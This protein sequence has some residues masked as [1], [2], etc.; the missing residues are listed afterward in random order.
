[1][2]MPLDLRRNFGLLVEH[3]MH[4]TPADPAKTNRIAPEPRVLEAEDGLVERDRL[5]HVTHGK[6]G[7]RAF[8][9]AVSFVGLIDVYG[10]GILACRPL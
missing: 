4:I 6:D 9:H 2:L 10:E 5:L 7:L 8:D 3:H 1:M